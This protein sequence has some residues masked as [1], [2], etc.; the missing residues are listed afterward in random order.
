MK[1]LPNPAGA[2]DPVTTVPVIEETVEVDKRIVDHGGWRITKQVETRDET[3]DEPLRHR[4]V[5]V[6]RRPIGSLVEG[7]EMPRQRY[8]GD[9]LVLPVVRE[10]V[11]TQKRLL[12]VEEIR[13]SQT[14]G[15]HRDPQQVTLRSETFSIERLEP[16]P[17]SE[18]ESP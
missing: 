4:R 18:P 13:I 2:G 16:E 15:T 6:E 8:E 9:V 11:V 1:A 14:E 10:V 17:R 5:N 7:D 12:L 3:V